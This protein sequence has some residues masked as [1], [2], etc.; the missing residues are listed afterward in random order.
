MQFALDIYQSLFEEVFD[1]DNLAWNPD[2][3]NSYIQLLMQKNEYL[4]AIE[5]KRTFIKHMVK[6][7][8]VDH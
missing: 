6:E 8:T 2:I 1:E 7:G 3:I 4:R 5:A